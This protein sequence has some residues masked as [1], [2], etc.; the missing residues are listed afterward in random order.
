MQVPASEEAKQSGYVEYNVAVTVTAVCGCVVCRVAFWPCM[1]RYCKIYAGEC[2]Y[3][4]NDF[5][6]GNEDAANVR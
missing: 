1:I 2:M 6:T 4:C 3:T 5:I